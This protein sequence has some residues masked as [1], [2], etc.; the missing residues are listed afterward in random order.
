MDI[1]AK[2][3]EWVR[4]TR[5]SLFSYCETLKQEDYVKELEGFG[6]WS[7]R[8]LHVHVTNCYEH[9]LRDFGLGQDPRYVKPEKV[10]NVEQM[11]KAFDQT[12]ELVEEFLRQFEGKWD[13]VISK[14]YEETGEAEELTAIWLLTHTVTHEFHHKGQIVSISRHL[15]YTP[16]DTDLIFPIDK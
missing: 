8:N 4:V 6:D 1:M 16:V 9:W 15:G 7:I 13:T 10:R 14:T 11:R 12:N 3:Y 5:E 2:Q